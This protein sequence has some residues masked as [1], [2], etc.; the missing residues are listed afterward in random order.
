[1]NTRLQPGGQPMLNFQKEGPLSGRLFEKVLKPESNG[2][3]T[4]NCYFIA[5][6][7]SLTFLAESTLN[8]LLR[9]LRSQGMTKHCPSPAKTSERQSTTHTMVKL[10]RRGHFPAGVRSCQTTSEAS[11]AQPGPV[12]SPLRRHR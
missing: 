11:P 5:E 12:A 8:K 10:A 3:A 6:Q 2:P 9:S 1:M 4:S 7:K